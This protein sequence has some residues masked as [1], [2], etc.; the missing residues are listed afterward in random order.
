V[1]EVRFVAIIR[2]DWSTTATGTNR[3]RSQIFIFGKPERGTTLAARSGGESVKGRKTLHWRYI[4]TY[5]QCGLSVEL[6][7]M[8]KYPLA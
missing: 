3:R 4:A 7:T 2:T 6:R 1:K 5:R 8:S